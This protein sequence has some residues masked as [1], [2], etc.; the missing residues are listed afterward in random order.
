MADDFD[1]TDEIQNL[2]DDELRELV[3]EK[4]RDEP[5]LHGDALGVHVSSGK[6]TVSGT[7]GTEEEQRILD[8]FLTDTVGLTD[9]RNNVVIDEL[10]RTQSPEAID[11]HLADEEEHEGLMI[12]DR[13]S[14]YTAESEHLADMPE[15]ESLEDPGGTHDVGKAIEGAEPWIPPEGPTP[16]GLSGLEN[17]GTFGH[18]TQH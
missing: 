4:L 3:I 7:V 1:N 5:M 18:D 8:H 14:Q 13:A 12:G 2:S 16:E 6:V 10:Y 11:E 15:I 9:I 17:V